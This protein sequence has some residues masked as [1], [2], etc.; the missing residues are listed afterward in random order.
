MN[1]NVDF[2]G[3]KLYLSQRSP[4]ARRVRLAFE[5]NGIRCQEV[6]LDVWKF[7]PDLA[8]L[9]PIHRVPTLELASGDVLFESGLILEL[10]YHSGERKLGFRSQ[11][12]YIRGLQ[13]AG[14]S[15]GLIEKTIERFL[16]TLRPEGERDP[17]FMTDLQR[18]S[19]QILN[20][21]EKE[22][23]GRQYIIGDLFTQADIDIATALTYLKFRYEAPVLNSYPRAR[24]YL[25]SLESRPAFKRAYPK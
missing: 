15:I 25:E 23:V 13:W 24:R 19:S 4:F 3:S 6:F 12:E 16:E 18:V 8:E 11:A 22:L 10:F 21:L 20:R 9:N 5:E 2:N 14:L 7:N 17:E 1:L